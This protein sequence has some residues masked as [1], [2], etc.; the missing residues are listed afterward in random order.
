MAA[1]AAATAA[2]LVAFD[3]FRLS[4]SACCAASSACSAVCA[5][6]SDAAIAV[7]ESSFV[8]CRSTLA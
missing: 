6:W 7:T 8:P 4:M 5:A 3:P 1:C 2:S